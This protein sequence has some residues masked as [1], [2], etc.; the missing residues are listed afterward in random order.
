MK[1][2]YDLKKRK[3][4]GSLHTHDGTINAL[5]FFQSSH[6]LS[7]SDDGTLAIYRTRDWEHLKTLQGHKGPVIDFA[8][9]PS[10]KLAISIGRDQTLRLWDL[11]KGRTAFIN[12]LHH[13]QDHF[14]TS[15]T[16]KFKPLPEKVRWNTDGTCYAVLYADGVDLFSAA[17]TEGDKSSVRHIYTGTAR[18]RMNCM[19]FIGFQDKDGVEQEALIVGYEDGYVRIWNCSDLQQP[20]ATLQVNSSSRL[21]AI[22][23]VNTDRGKIM[24]TISSDGIV[25]CWDLDSIVG[26]NGKEEAAVYKLGQYETGSRLICLAIQ[27]F[28][29][30]DSTIEE[31]TQVAVQEQ[32][33]ESDD[34]SDEN[35]PVNV[36]EENVEKPEPKRKVKLKVSTRK[37]QK[38]SD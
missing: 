16:K 6:L 2:L 7:A 13:S 22:Q 11:L 24:V 26:T 23:T 34:N 32:V 27:D 33:E 29:L 12:R 18:Q 8:I 14:E 38:K 10:G 36:K 25:S 20:I 19:E 1:R 31:Q 5:Q 28:S 4:I 17:Q 35:E 37:R 15:I 9:H 3:E 21:K 30:D